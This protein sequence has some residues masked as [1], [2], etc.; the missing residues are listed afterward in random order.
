MPKEPTNSAQTTWGAVGFRCFWEVEM[1][2]REQKVFWHGVA[3]GTMV[4]VVVGLMIAL[5]LTI[6][7]ELFRL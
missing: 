5:F 1:T 2:T 7:P 6:R 4:G 3:A